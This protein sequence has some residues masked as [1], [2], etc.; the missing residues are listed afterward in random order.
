MIDYLLSLS[1][2]LDLNSN[3]ILEVDSLSGRTSV[4]TGNVVVTGD[5]LFNAA[6]TSDVGSSA[7]PSDTVYARSVLET[8]HNAAYQFLVV[9]N[10]QGLSHSTTA[11][12]FGATLND[13]ITFFGVYLEKAIVLG[14]AAIGTGTLGGSCATRTFGV[15]VYNESLARVDTTAATGWPGNGTGGAAAFVSHTVAGPGF[16]YFCW[17]TYND[18]TCSQ[19]FRGPDLSTNTVFSGILTSINTSRPIVGYASESL[20]NGL[21]WPATITLNKSTTTTFFPN[22]YISGTNLD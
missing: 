6:N 10:V 13:T 4:W 1:G 14:E 8:G 11:N 9:P 12:A 16:V 20:N 15:G 18:G 5:I 21:G 7:A 17:S 2:N 22:I 19:V 3:D